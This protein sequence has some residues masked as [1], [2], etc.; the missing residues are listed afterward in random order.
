MI[1]LTMSTSLAIS[2]LSCQF[3]FT[4]DVDQEKSMPKNSPLDKRISGH[5]GI[6]GLL[7]LALISLIVPFLASLTNASFPIDSSQIIGNTMRQWL[8]LQ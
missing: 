2:R 7:F 8:L 4:I 6:E 1:R 5:I 3:N